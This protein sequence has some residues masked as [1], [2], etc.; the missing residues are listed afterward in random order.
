MFKRAFEIVDGIA[1]R[2]PDDAHSR[3]LLTAAAQPL[4]SLLRNTSPTEALE[5]QD[6]AL[7][8]LAEVTD[9]EKARRYEARSLAASATLLQRMGRM[10]EA[11]KR[12]EGARMRLEELK[13][14]PAAP[15]EAGSEAEEF[16]MALAE[17]QVASGDIAAGLATCETLLGIA[18]ASDLAPE[19]D[20]ADA[21][22]VSYLYATVA[23]IQRRAGKAESAAALE[24]RRKALWQ[25]W[26]GKRPD[27]VFVRTR[28]ATPDPR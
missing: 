8:H 5:I 17:F 24:T 15:V 6:H 26:I 7:R 21:A 13:L 28:L 14:Y 18:S 11:R 16:L 2:D 25:H 4:A 1:H 9:N 27:D 3:E 10:D 20:L 12:L 19:E 22:E 23:A